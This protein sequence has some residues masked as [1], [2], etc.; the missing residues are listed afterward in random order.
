MRGAR[1]FPP[2]CSRLF[3]SEKTSESEIKCYVSKQKGF[4][5]WIDV[6]HVKNVNK[7]KYYRVVTPRAATKGGEGFGNI[8]ISKPNECISDTYISMPVN[9]E[10]EANS[11]K[12]YLQTKFANKMLSVRKI[13]Q[14]IKPD[15]LKWIPIVPLDRK[16]TDEQLYTYFDLTNDEIKFIEK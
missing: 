13:S 16:W 15:T 10:L 7:L 6:K 14:H 5:K 4:E 3:E 1:P 11:L 2:S 9:S 8:F 12:S